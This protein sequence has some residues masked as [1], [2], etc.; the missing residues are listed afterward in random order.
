MS[1]EQKTEE[2]PMR[3]MEK[4]IGWIFLVALLICGI[5]GLMIV[6][7][8]WP[9]SDV[10]VATAALFGDSF[11][12]L[13]AFFSGLAFL[14][15]AVALVFQKQD[16]VLQRDELKLTRKELS[17]QRDE[18]KQTR[19]EFQAQNKVLRKQSFESTFFQMVRLHHD[20]VRDIDIAL[21]HRTMSLTGRDCFIT[22]GKN[23][24]AEYEKFKSSGMDELEKLDRAYHCFS[25]RH[26]QDVGHYFRN[27][28]AIISFVDEIDILD[29]QLY[30]GIVGAQ[31]SECELLLLFYHA[32]VSDGRDRFK[33]SAIL[34]MADLDQ[35]QHRW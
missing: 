21:P 3:T 26:K 7:L 6:S 35:L 20:I 8:T 13:A 15:M 11:G 18:L 10:S 16:L 12:V 30:M 31:L 33:P 22:F 1:E 24:A 9:V 27:L 28:Y 32:L 2:G 14:T 23:L 5:Y 19:Q 29:K 34:I 17:L 4:A 25:D